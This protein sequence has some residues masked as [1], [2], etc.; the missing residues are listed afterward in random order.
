MKI[1]K[2]KEQIIF[3]EIFFEEGDIKLNMLETLSL[4]E[5]YRIAIIMKHFKITSKEF[6][7]AF[8]PKPMSGSGIRSYLYNFKTEYLIP[9]YLITF[10]NLFDDAILRNLL[11][12]Y[13][14]ENFKEVIVQNYKKKELNKI[15]T[16]KKIVQDEQMKL[17]KARIEAEKEQLKLEKRKARAEKAREKRRSKLNHN[18]NL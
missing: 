18:S 12:D 5:S 10:I 17:N 4:I 8:R 7:N 3:G 11:K 9:K 1:N 16:S 2:T 13:L 6:G 15:E 14:H